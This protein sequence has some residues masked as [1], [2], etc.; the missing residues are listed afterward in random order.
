MKVVIVASGAMAPGDEEQLADADLVVAADGGADA[1]ERLGRRP[2]LLV[3][4]LDSV[5][6]ATA[7]RLGAEGTGIE[8][9]PVD[10]EA[11][12]TALAVRS[13]LGAGA[14]RLVLLGTAGGERLDHAIANLLL[15]ADPSL[16]GTDARLV[17]GP[18]TVRLLSG[19][20]V[21]RLDGLPGD[22][23]SLLPLG[24]PARGVT[25]VGLRWALDDAE[26]TPGSTRGLSNE[27][28]EAPASVSLRDGRLV[29]VE[30]RTTTRTESRTP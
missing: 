27:V 13:A 7:D 23:V 10:K 18:S 11:S 5:S 25:T 2:D 15:L 24:D 4:D 20:G 17:S 28:V 21:A 16:T 30:H 12:D 26:L 3:G 9:H 29:V 8:R 14:S 22:L 1:L 19:S 6:P